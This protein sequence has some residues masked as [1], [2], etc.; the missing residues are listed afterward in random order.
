MKSLESFRKI[1]NSFIFDP[2]TAIKYQKPDTII[3]FSTYWNLDSNFEVEAVLWIVC[4]K[5]SCL[6]HSYPQYF[7]KKF[8]QSSLKYYLPCKSHCNSLKRT[9][10]SQAWKSFTNSSIL[11]IEL[12]RPQVLHLFPPLQSSIYKK[13]FPS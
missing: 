8:K 12:F 13:K 4:I 6:Y 3:S 10:S 7:H 9:K 11:T 5:T 1:S 2:I